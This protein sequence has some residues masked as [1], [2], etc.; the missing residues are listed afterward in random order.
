VYNDAIRELVVGNVIRELM[1]EESQKAVES[2]GPREAGELVEDDDAKLEEKPVDESVSTR[3]RLRYKRKRY[4]RR[5]L[6]E[7]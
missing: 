7:R 6:H 3:P 5:R 4:T 2:A 1:L